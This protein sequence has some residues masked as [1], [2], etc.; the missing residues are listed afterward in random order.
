MNIWPKCCSTFILLIVH[1]YDLNNQTNVHNQKWKRGT[2]RPCEWQVESARRRK[3][4][5][6]MTFN[7]QNSTKI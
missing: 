4:P 7:S 1:I 3:I 5:T 2:R 6:F